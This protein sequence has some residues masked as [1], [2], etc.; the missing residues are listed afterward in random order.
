MALE[1]LLNYSG[2]TV[3]ENKSVLFVAYSSRQWS[4]QDFE[5]VELYPY[6]RPGEH[7][8]WFDVIRLLPDSQCTKASDPIEI[9]AGDSK[10]MA[11]QMRD[12]AQQIADSCNLPFIEAP[13]TE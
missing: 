10:T 5:A 3:T 1:G 6:C 13:K 8:R 2:R 7:P 12:L 9:G 4:V 11:K